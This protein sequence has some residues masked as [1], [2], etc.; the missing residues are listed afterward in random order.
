MKLVEKSHNY[1]MNVLAHVLY[2]VATFMEVPPV[3][4]GFKSRTWEP[5]DLIQLI[6]K[7]ANA[8]DQRPHILRF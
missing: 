4:P 3:L 8:H 6:K 5:D 7:L 1:F 2:T